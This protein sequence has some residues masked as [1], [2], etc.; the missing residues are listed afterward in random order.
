MHGLN[1]TNKSLS[2]PVVVLPALRCTEGALA[3][4]P[5][6]LH[7]CVPDLPGGLQDAG[8]GSV[9]VH[10][11]HQRTMLHSKMCGG[12]YVICLHAAKGSLQS[13]CGTSSNEKRQ[14]PSAG[15]PSYVSRS[16]DKENKRT[17]TGSQQHGTCI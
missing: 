2:R 17:Q 10:A 11:S 1:S 5:E 12:H 16:C 13:F 4:A 14:V 3:A 7:R 8:S 6:F 9:F 15:H